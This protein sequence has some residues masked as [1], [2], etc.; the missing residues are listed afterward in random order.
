MH[1]DAGHNHDSGNSRLLRD[2]RCAL[3]MDETEL[4]EKTIYKQRRGSER[5][6]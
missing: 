4:N 3:E 6:N 2:R 1:L 5:N